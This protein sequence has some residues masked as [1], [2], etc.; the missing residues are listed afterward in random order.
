MGLFQRFNKASETGNGKV[1]SLLNQKGGVGKTT[2]VFNLAHALK[3]KG[4][5]VLC[6]DMDPQANLSHLFDVQ[7]EE[8]EDSIFQ[9]LVNNI[10]ELKAIHRPVLFSEVV[11]SVDGI[12]IVA[13]AQ[14]LSGLELTIAGISSPRQL[15][16][17]NFIEK[18]NLKSEYDFILVDGAPTLG[19]LMVNILC[20]S[21]GVLVP[22]QPDQFSRKGL[23]HFHDVVEQVSDMGITQTPEILGY[24]PNLVLERRKQTQNDFDD[25]REDLSL[26]EAKI[27]SPFLNRVHLAKSAGMKKS[28]FHYSSKEF[29]EIQ[30]QFLGIVD[31]IEERFE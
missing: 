3:E 11:K 4:H 2:M 16:L 15:V 7:L 26:D 8:N 18:N 17:K 30:S 28:V 14:D 23:G 1:I 19:L 5:R 12:D 24:I 9:L 22:F 10:R 29:K 21:D 31:E 20:A 25:I 27:F 6:L 13:S